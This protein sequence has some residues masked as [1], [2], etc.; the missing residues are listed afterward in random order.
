MAKKYRYIGQPTPRK[1]AVPIVTGRAVYI[2]DVKLPGML[3]GKVLR[4]P[5]PHALIEEI[6]TEDALKVP[7]VVTV[8]T[9]KDVPSDWKLGLPSH[10]RVLD[11][12]VRFVGDA[13]ALV[14]AETEEAALE[15]LD[16]IKVK[17]RVLP[18]VYDP[19]EAIKPGAPQLYDEFPN[20]LL[21]LG[22][23]WF[24][25]KRAPEGLKELV[26]GDVEKGFAEADVVAEGTFTYEN[27]TN[28]LPPEPPGAIA[29]WEDPKTVHVWLSSQGFYMDKISLYYIMR[30]QYNVI[31]HACQCGGSYGSKGTILPIA[32]YAIVL[33]KAAG[34][35]V[36]LCYTKEEHLTCFT[37]RLGTRIRAKVGM[38]KDGTVT[39]I[40]GEWFTDT[41]YYSAVTQGQIAVGLGEAQL[42]I[43]CP[44]WDLRPKLVCTNR[45]SSGWIRGFGGQELKSALLPLLY[46]AMEKLDIDPVEFFKK[47]VIKAGE[48]YFWRDGD[49]WV[50]RVI[51]FTKAIDRG[52]QVFGWKEKW[53]G[54][55]KPTAVEGPKRRGVGVGVHG[56]ADVGEDDAEAWVRIDPDHTATLYV[57][58]PEQGGGQRSNLC[59][60][61]AEVLQIPLENV[62]LSPPRSDV[63][64]Y[65]FGLVGS[66]GTY[67]IGSAVIEAAEDAKKKLFEMAAQ[68]LGVS[69]DKLDTVD[70]VIF[71]K[72]DPEKQ[73]TWRRA[74]GP[75]RTLWGYGRFE[76]DYSLC[77]FMISFVEV[78][79]DTETGKV[80][81]VR[82]VNATDAGQIIDPPSLENQLNGCIGSAG[83]DTAIFEETVLD[84]EIGRI[85]TSN[86]IDYKWR[87]FPDLPEIR[88]VILETPFPSHKFGAVG[89]GEIATSPGPPAV[90]MAV[91]NAIGRWVERY[92]ATPAVVLEALGKIK[93]GQRR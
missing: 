82:V 28:P 72:D 19:E 66:R 77:N 16:R 69:P 4:S 70:G 93:G 38:K 10:L 79:V 46:R 8:L 11:R 59:K 24:G 6:D 27:I 51:D 64:P 81:L 57:A 30:R 61:V 32:M 55:L 92:P 13:V 18:A 49:W 73:I 21:P 31:V 74:M 58:V 9:H 34:R 91:S 37:L 86:L 26:M 89:V 25:S 65:E 36:K 39:A 5:H 41:G 35:P 17:Y 76:P 23:P 83:I 68:K 75:T 20:N 14:A 63:N 47:N 78:E 50:S 2:N 48:G 15:A 44:N 52:A 56:N 87:L 45:N 88:N 54:W 84:R 62:F 1:D 7:G 22:N 3:I 85:L 42:V 71:V 33:A 90:L 80:D 40:A 53:K 60:M 12:K 43:R 67:A 29:Y